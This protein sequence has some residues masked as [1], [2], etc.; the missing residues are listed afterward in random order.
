MATP[1][2][3]A[4]VALLA[5]L[6]A[7]AQQAEREERMSSSVGLRRDSRLEAVDLAELR[8]RLLAD[9]L[10]EARRALAGLKDGER[11]RIFSRTAR[12]LYP[13]S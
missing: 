3:L 2:W 10:V 9:L 12:D 1:N 7:S 11:E 5:P 4:A 13:A 8:G 6:A